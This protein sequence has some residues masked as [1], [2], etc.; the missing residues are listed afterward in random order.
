M[1]QLSIWQ[2]KTILQ[3]ILHT[4]G[5]PARLISQFLNPCF[6]NIFG[7]W[8]IHSI[9]GAFAQEFNREYFKF[10]LQLSPSAI[11]SAGALPVITNALLEIV[12]RVVASAPMATVM[13]EWKGSQGRRRVEL[14]LVCGAHWA[15]TVLAGGQ[16]SHWWGWRHWELLLTLVVNSNF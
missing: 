1:L 11:A 7:P 16:D 8:Y 13:A 6:S 2:A 9:N 3:H 4:R 14:T 5:I 10:M 15:L 12:D